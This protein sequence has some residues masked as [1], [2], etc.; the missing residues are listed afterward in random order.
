[1]LRA[2]LTKRVQ[3]RLKRL[4]GKDVHPDSLHILHRDILKVT[5]KALPHKGIPHKD[6]LLKD[7]PLKVT[8]LLRAIPHRDTLRKAT[9]FRDTRR[10][11]PHQ[12]NTPRQLNN[13][14]QHN[15]RHLNQH[16]KHL[17]FRLM[18]KQGVSKTFPLFFLRSFFRFRVSFSLSL[19]IYRNRE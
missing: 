5:L 18:R 3:C 11:N 14:H 13:P 15:S 7:I 16:N 19:A 8:T 12:P 17:L 1:M 10:N 4:T 6:I 9:L 2:K